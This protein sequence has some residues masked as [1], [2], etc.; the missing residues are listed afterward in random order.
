M[1]F[2]AIVAV[3]ILSLIY[4]SNSHTF[5][6]GIHLKYITSFYLF[7]FFLPLSFSFLSSS[8]S[9]K[10]KVFLWF[11]KVNPFFSKYFLNLFTFFKSFSTNETMSIMS[12]FRISFSQLPHLLL[13]LFPSFLPRLLYVHW[14]TFIK[15]PCL[16]ASKKFRLNFYPP[17]LHSS[18]KCVH[19]SPLQHSTYSHLSQHSP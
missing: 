1:S 12:N 7:Y 16:S 19:D 14:T 3:F 6:C 15:H 11:L 10:L 8:S 17:S 13:S 18:S 5:F 4:L 2:I 9:F